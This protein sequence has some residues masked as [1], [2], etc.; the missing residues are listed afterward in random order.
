MLW[1]HHKKKVNE[2][3][4]TRQT[5]C[6]QGLFKGSSGNSTPPPKFYFFGGKS[7][8]KEVKREGIKNE[9]G[10]GMWRVYTS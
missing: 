1:C 2:G 4:F 9:N 5:Y 8:G 7:D 6:C 10:C 3:G